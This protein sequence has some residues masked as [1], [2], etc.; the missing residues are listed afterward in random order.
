MITKKIV[1]TGGGEIGR[2]GYKIETEKI[3]RETV[4]LSG[5][6]KPNLVLLP[7]ASGDSPLYYEVVSKYFGK[8]LG[9]KIKVIYL[10][11]NR[12]PAKE[13]S[14]IIKSADIVYVGGGNTLRMLKMWRKVG[15]D[16]MLKNAWQNGCVM[17]GVS[18]G[19][20]CWFRYA[21]SDSRKFS[22]SSASY[23]RIRGLDFVPATCAPH[24]KKEEKRRPHLKTIMKY[25]PGVAVAIDDWAVIQIV[26]D[27]FRIVSSRPE[28]NCFQVYRKKGKYYENVL[29]KNQWGSL[30]DLLKKEII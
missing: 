28:S 5:K 8:R 17:S 21:S 10:F 3:D 6:K 19:A 20:I 25:T 16:K 22:D 29:A 30:G 15:V 27:K 14:D 18:A 23:I 2:P 1:A 11:K 12:W 13:I 26:D 9:C 4:E 24:F 7:T